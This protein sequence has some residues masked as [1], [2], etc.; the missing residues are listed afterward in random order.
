MWNIYNNWLIMSSL[1][2]VFKFIVTRLDQSI[3]LDM[4]N[5]ENSIT[6]VYSKVTKNANNES[7]L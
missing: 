5:T 7:R 6:Y 4:I 2:V 3:K 1:P